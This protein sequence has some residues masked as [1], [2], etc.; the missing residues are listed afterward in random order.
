MAKPTVVPLLNGSGPGLR[1]VMD[2]ADAVTIR[3]AQDASQ[4]LSGM[5]LG[6]DAQGNSW[7]WNGGDFDQVT[8]AP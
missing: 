6:P 4:T 1:V 7:A 3:Q 2:G 8:P 5:I